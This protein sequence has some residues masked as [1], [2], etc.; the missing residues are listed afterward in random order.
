MHCIVLAL[1]MPGGTGMGLE[2][3]SAA[4]MYCIRH[5]SDQ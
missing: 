3:G 1:G 4:C 5:D 2:G